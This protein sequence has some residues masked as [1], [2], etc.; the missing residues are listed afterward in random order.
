MFIIDI[1]LNTHLVN[2][3]YDINGGAVVHPVRI[4]VPALTI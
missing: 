2:C 1:I 3:F 4:G